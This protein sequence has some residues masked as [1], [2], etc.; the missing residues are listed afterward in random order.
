MQRGA[1]ALIPVAILAICCTCWGQHCGRMYAATNIGLPGPDVWHPDTWL[2]NEGE[3]LWNCMAGVLGV[4]TCGPL[5]LSI[6]AFGLLKMLNVQ[7]A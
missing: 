4:S 7:G 1:A 6:I 3:P 5:P 2:P